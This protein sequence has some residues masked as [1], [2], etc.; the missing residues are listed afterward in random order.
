M[1]VEKPF[2]AEE[3]EALSYDELIEHVRLSKVRSDE[4]IGLISLM[5]EEIKK[6][7]PTIDYQCPHC[8]NKSYTEYQTRISGG[9]MSSIFDVGN[10]KLRMV[11]CQRCN[12]SELYKGKV[13][14]AEQLV[15]FL[16]G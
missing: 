2:D 6:R 12:R 13:G 1:K 9:R 14:M 10:I 4:Y 8:Q 3:I 5:K 11:V 15:D 16:V 7:E